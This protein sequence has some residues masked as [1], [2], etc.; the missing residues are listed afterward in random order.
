MGSIVGFAETVGRTE[1]VGGMEIVGRKLGSRVVGFDVGF[2]DVG[3]GVLD[4]TMV[5]EEVTV[6][7]VE[8]LGLGFKL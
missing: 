5:G 7:K 2:A 3:R 4:G 6:G 1:I 8:G